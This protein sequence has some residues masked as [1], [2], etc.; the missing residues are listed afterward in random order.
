MSLD[1]P[2]NNKMV[3]KPPAKKGFHFAATGEYQAVF[4]EATTIEEA[5][6]IYQKVKRPISQPA[7]GED[8]T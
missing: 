3:T 6:Q 5:E 4:I 1:A 8:V 2:Q 7:E